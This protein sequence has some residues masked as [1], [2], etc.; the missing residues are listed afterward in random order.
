MLATNIERNEMELICI[1]I[2]RDRQ[3]DRESDRISSKKYSSILE[4]LNTIENL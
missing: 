1:Y 3:T 4:K 2:E